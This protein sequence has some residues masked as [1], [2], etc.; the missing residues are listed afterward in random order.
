MP[1]HTDTRV[2]RYTPDQMFDLVATVERYPEFLPW[3][4]D[5]RVR[6]RTETTIQ[7][8]MVIG[9]KIFTESFLTFTE[10]HRPGQIDVVY[11]D[12]PFKYLTS[13]WKF[14][15]HDRGC[16]VEFQIDFEFR[17]GL[18]QRAIKLVFTDAV[19]VMTRSFERRARQVYGRHPQAKS[20]L[21]HSA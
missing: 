13:Q 14:H 5:L 3:C 1:K 11:K 20:P 7:S 19:K 16:Q 8:T 4:Q 17:S 9:Y 18:L 6:E 21:R 15:P 2:M 10:L 12:G